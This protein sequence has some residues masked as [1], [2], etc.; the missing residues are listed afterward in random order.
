MPWWIT[1]LFLIYIYKE[2][3]EEESIRLIEDANV[4]ETRA[5]ATSSNKFKVHSNVDSACTA[6]PLCN[7]FPY[8][9]FFCALFFCCWRLRCSKATLPWLDPWR[10][11]MYIHVDCNIK[12]RIAGKKIGGIWDLFTIFLLKKE[13]WIRRSW[14]WWQWF[15]SRTYTYQLETCDAEHEAVDVKKKKKRVCL[16]E[17][18]L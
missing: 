12:R 14:K 16:S 11:R 1:R 5:S 15:R 3:E 10:W 4:R 6:T 7:I 17:T 18:A 2:E 8:F 13:R 9:S